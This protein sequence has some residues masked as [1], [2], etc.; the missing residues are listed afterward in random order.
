M[1]SSA[2]GGCWPA[3]EAV[4]PAQRGFTLVEIAVVLAVVG[5]LCAVAWPGFREPLLRSRRADAVTALTRIQ[6]AQESHRALHGLYASQLGALS[7]AASTRSP[8]GLYD[9]ELQRDGPERYEAR[10]TARADGL[11]SGD[12]ACRVLRLLVREGIAEFAPT[13]RCWNR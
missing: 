2:T 12:S 1:H 11:M 4:R 9:I 3:T 6:I 8:E 13:A 5:I 10:A 7:G